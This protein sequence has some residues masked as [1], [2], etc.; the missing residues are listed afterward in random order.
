MTPVNPKCAA[1]GLRCLA[2]WFDVKYQDAGKTDEVQRDLR[3]WADEFEK[4]EADIARLPKTKDGVVAYPGDEVWHP[5]QA[6]MSKPFIVGA[7]GWF[8]GNDEEGE[9]TAS[10]YSTREAAEKAAQGQEREAD[11][12]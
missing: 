7:D 9:E 8:A 11:R 1:E 5:E 4:A 12:G 3:R 6:D 2:D 10:C